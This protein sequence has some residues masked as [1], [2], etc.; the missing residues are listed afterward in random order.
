MESRSNLISVV[1]LVISGK[2]LQMMTV[3]KPIAFDVTICMS[4]LFDYYLYAVSS[5]TM[6]VCVANCGKISCVAQKLG[7]FNQALFV[8][9]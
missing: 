4:Q 1:F 2:Y 3:L 9:F 8:L 6:C 5:S 7:L